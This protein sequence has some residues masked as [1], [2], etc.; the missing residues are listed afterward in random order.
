VPARKRSW[1]LLSDRHYKLSDKER[2]PRPNLI[3]LPSEFS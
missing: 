1:D 3:K 2:K